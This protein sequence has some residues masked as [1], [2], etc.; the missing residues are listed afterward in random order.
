MD[1]IAR[2][3]AGLERT[4]KSYGSGAA[5]IGVKLVKSSRFSLVTTSSPHRE[6]HKV[7]RKAIAQG[8]PECSPLHLYVRVQLFACTTMRVQRAPGTPAPLF[9]E[10]DE[11]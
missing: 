4:V 10:G 2:P 11:I 3:A 8:L 6:D 5:M 1:A 7:S 9:G